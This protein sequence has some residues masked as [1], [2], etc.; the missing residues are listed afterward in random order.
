MKTAPAFDVRTPAEYIHGHIPGA[1]N[2][3]L[4][5]DEERAVIGT[6]YTRESRA[7]A[8]RKG[9]SF[10]GPRMGTMIE[11]VD[12][13]ANGSKEVLVHCWRGGMRSE[14][15]AWLLSFAGYTVFTLEGGYKTF[16]HWMIDSFAMVKY[17]IILGGRTG[18]GKTKMLHALADAGEQ[19]LDLEAAASHK[20]S[21]FGAIGEAPQ[22]TQEHFENLIGM[23][24]RSF[25]ADRTVWV[26]DESPK[27]GK[28]HIPKPLWTMM[29]TAPVVYLDVSSETRVRNLIPE[30]VRVEKSELTGYLEKIRERLGG[31]NTAHAIDAVTRG[32]YA[33]AVGVVLRYYDKTYDYCLSRRTEASIIKVPA[34]EGDTALLVKRL[35]DAR[36]KV[37]RKERA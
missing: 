29:E 3:P 22:P 18:A 37:Q 13:I 31:E 14:S 10:I 27:V 2:L 25:D 6:A 36:V 34:G 15:V 7:V 30:Y 24:L 23:A 33:D 21:V 12:R 19:V 32:D 28:L 4:F 5:T 8:I 26:E 1:H 35:L 16:R 11:S 17:I 20:G 9:L